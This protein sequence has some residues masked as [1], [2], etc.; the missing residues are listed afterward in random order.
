MRSLLVAASLMLIAC[1]GTQP[2][3]DAS[4]NEEVVIDS[5]I[6][7][8]EIDEREPED[9]PDAGE[10]SSIDEEIDAGITVDAGVTFDAGVS[11][12]AGTDHQ[13]FRVMSWNVRGPLDTGAH[14]WPNRRANVIALIKR[15]SP[16]IVGVQEAQIA[17]GQDIP[18]D[19]IAGLQSD[20]GY[21]RPSGGSP[22]IIFYKKTRF[23]PFAQ[24]NEAL[25]NP[26]AATH[27]CSDRSTGKKLAWAKLR[28]RLTNKEY[29]VGNTHLA[30]SDTCGLGRLRQAEEIK[31]LV[32]VRAAT[33]PVIVFG[34]FNTDDQKPSLANEGVVEVMEGTGRTLFRTARHDG[35]TSADDATFNSRWNGSGT[36]NARID[37]IFHS[38]RDITSSAPTVDR[39]P[40]TDTGTPSDHFPIIATIRAATFEPASTLVQVT[41]GEN[42]NTQVFF[43]DVDGDGCADQ[44]SWSATFG[45][46]STWWAKSRC[47]GTFAAPLE[48]GG[49]TSGAATTRFFFA[50]VTGDRCAE[51]I[52]WRPNYDSGRVRIYRGRC[53][54]T[55]DAVTIANVPASTSE[56]TQFFFA[57]I[58]AD[59]CADLVRWSPTENSGRVTVYASTCDGTVSFAASTS[60]TQLVDDTRLWFADVDGDRRDDLIVWNPQT[61]SGQTRV[62]KSDGNGSFTSLFTHTAGSSGVATSRFAFA[63]LDGDGLADK[64]FWRPTFRNGRAQIYPGTGTNFASSPLMDNTGWSQSESTTF[65]YADTDGDGAA[66]K[67]YWNPGSNGGASKVFRSRH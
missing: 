35:N 25:P 19:L 49:A 54:G 53:D 13:P 28:D 6:V 7:D 26:Y 46:G 60:G 31:R 37:F 20:Y 41:D 42:T 1:G 63:D 65:L 4:P 45:S 56:S 58:T 14:A 55:F 66:D 62:F 27:V 24:G 64:V 32:D 52:Y 43:A 12:D 39:W 2:P 11:V 3:E 61:S 22:K 48:M 38:G 30:F 51:K 5:G 15:Q 10:E 36:N 67:T 57:K 8:P 18:A 33:L 34:D 17:N 9:P 59:A 44:L 29:F 50:D 40:D 21:Y 47:N 23:T 16:D